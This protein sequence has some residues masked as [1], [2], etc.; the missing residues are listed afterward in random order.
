MCESPSRHRSVIHPGLPDRRGGPI[1]E[2]VGC[3]RHKSRHPACSIASSQPDSPDAECKNWWA[4]PMVRGFKRS[5]A[6]GGDSCRG[7]D[8]G[9]C[10][11]WATLRHEFRSAGI[12]GADA[13]YCNSVPINSSRARSSSRFPVTPEKERSFPS[14]RSMA[15]TL[16]YSLRSRDRSCRDQ[17][18]RAWRRWIW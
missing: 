2:A 13:R 3:H 8:P 4:G 12:P 17:A 7:R 15:R 5:R 11:A 9:G 10:A 1:R 6:E 14:A 18:C 16:R